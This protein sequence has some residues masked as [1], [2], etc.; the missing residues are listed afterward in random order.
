MEKSKNSLLFLLGTAHSLNHSLFL[1]LPLY[2]SQVAQEF[3]TTKE[4]VGF[5][6]AV[7]GFIYGAGSLFGGPL[8]DKIGE[9]KAL[10]I[11]MVFSGVSTFL[12][13]AAHDVTGFATCL[14]LMGL[15]GSLYHPTANTIIA[16][17]FE[18]KMAEA[19]GLHGTGGNVGYMIAPLII[20]GLG[21]PWGWRYPLLFFGLLTIALSLIIMRLFSGVD[22]TTSAEEKE[23]VNP[24]GL[25]RT[26]L[27]HGLL[28]LLAYNLVVGLY[29]KGVDFIFPSFLQT[30]PREYSSALKATAIT[31]LLGFGILGQWLCGKA[32]NRVGSRKVLIATSIGI[33]SSMILLLAVPDP[34]LSVALFVFV[35]GTMFYG[36]QP[37]LNSLTGLITPSSKRGVVYGVFFFFSFGLGSISIAIASYFAFAYSMEMAFVVLLLISIVALVLS[38]FAPEQ[39]K[40]SKAQ[41]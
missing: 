9:V 23:I 25:R 20:V 29:F 15:G 5:I 13:F 14:L 35:Y 30:P 28:I 37:A 11:G 36:H 17:A 22:K 18:G 34:V 32:S 41:G 26:F 40:E 39:P 7:S 4:T 24:K 16:K 2:L 12:F 19:M 38:F 6:A 27:I 10:M 3:T 8:S 31:L 1:V 33:T 21:D